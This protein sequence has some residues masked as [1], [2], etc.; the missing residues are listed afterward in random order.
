MRSSLRAAALCA[1][2]VLGLP[3]SA[4]AQATRSISISEAKAIIHHVKA[5]EGGGYAL[6]GC[7][8]GR[9]QTTCHLSEEYE[10]VEEAEG[11]PKVASSITLRY[12][13]HLYIKHHRVY[14]VEEG[15]ELPLSI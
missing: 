8:R 7:V 12:A 9:R 13:V 5:H 14:V 4:S 1:L 6:E 15:G 3:A 11:G 2:A 10:E